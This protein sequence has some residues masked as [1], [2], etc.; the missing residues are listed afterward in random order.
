MLTLG[1]QISHCACLTASGS[2]SLFLSSLSG[3]LFLSI[4]ASCWCFIF[5]TESGADGMREERLKYFLVASVLCA[6]A[7]ADGGCVNIPLFELSAR[8]GKRDGLSPFLVALMEF[9]SLVVFGR[10]CHDCSFY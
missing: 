6:F 5:L 2:S 1:S 7:A 8:G 3:S 4:S 10:A 9:L